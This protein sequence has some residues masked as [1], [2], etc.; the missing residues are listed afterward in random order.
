MKQ[1]SRAIQVWNCSKPPN[2]LRYL[3]AGGMWI[4]LESRISLGRKKKPQNAAES[5][6]SGVRFVGLRLLIIKERLVA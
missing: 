2:G 1:S 3:L 5:R 6:Q 4:R